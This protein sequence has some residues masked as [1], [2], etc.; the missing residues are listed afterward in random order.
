MANQL[1][2]AKKAASRQTSAAIGTYAKGCG[3]GFVQLPESGPTWQ[4]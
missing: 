1:F 4:A 3:A 2:G